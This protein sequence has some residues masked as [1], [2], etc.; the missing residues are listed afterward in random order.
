[1]R[2][3]KKKKETGSDVNNIESNDS[4]VA[5]REKPRHRNDLEGGYNSDDEHP[6][7]EEGLQNLFS[8]GEDVKERVY[9]T[10]FFFDIDTEISKNVF[11]KQLKLN[12]RRV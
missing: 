8:L 10:G 1:M 7:V 9:M 11:R 4:Y 5:S 12:S 3:I 6:T 2:I